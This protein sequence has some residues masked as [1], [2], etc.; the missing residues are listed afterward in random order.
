MEIRPGIQERVLALEVPV[1]SDQGLPSSA[2]Y[3][4]SSGPVHGFSVRS[5]Q[6]IR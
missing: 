5:I 4:H 2:P 6:Y 1:F 3:V